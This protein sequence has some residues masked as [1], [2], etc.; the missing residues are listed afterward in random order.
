M[1][2]LLQLDFTGAFKVRGAGHLKRVRIADHFVD[3][4]G[5]REVG[6]LVNLTGAHRVD[7]RVEGRL[8]SS[9]PRPGSVS[10]IPPACRCRLQIS[11]ISSVLMV[12]LNWNT[13]VA[14]A[15]RMGVDPA[16]VALR[17]RINVNDPVLARLLFL[18]ADEPGFSERGFHEQSIAECLVSDACAV[19]LKTRSVGLGGA[20]LRRVVELCRSSSGWMPRLADMAS[21]ANMSYFHFARSFKV[22]TGLSPHAYVLRCRTEQALDL[23]ACSDLPVKAISR[24]AGFTHT[25]HLAR[26]VRR[27][28]GLSPERY[29]QQV[30]P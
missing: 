28:T 5:R 15:E 12:S 22:A 29:R 16:Q 14:A 21:E 11:G 24:E 19:Q 23:L 10:V 17:P 7:G 20:T 18:S 4:D 9:A 1:T 30:L 27:A 2:E 3:I 13:F 6:L 26:H 8:V 25:S